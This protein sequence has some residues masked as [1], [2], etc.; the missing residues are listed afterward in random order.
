MFSARKAMLL[1][2]ATYHVI[3]EQFDRTIFIKNG[4]HGAPLTHTQ[5][6]AYGASVECEESSLVVGSHLQK[7]SQVVSLALFLILLS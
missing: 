7:A 2:P 6:R 3:Y 4:H 1:L 5:E